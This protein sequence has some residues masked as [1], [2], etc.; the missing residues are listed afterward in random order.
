MILTLT[1][2]QQ[3]YAAATQDD[4]DALE[5]TIREL[6]NNRFQLPNVRMTGLAVEGNSITGLTGDTTGLSAG[7]TI[8]IND[9]EYNDGVYTVASVT[10]TT[11]TVTEEGALTPETATSA[12]VTRVKYPPDIRRGVRQLLAYD[13]K[14]RAKTGIKSE[15]IARMSV[16]YYDVNAND[17]AE[18][19]PKA[20]LDFVRKYEKLRW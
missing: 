9:S 20:L 5:Q 18:G 1:E 7:D 17:N 16:T 2:A 11:I 19:Y 4:L 6:T 12:I 14:M 3:I 10:A 8:E 15:S 13:A